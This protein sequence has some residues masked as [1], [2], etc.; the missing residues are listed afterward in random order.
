MAEVFDGNGWDPELAIN[1]WVYQKERARLGPYSTYHKTKLIVA[2]DGACRDNGKASAKA[3]VGVYFG[4]GN[5][6]NRA[7][8]LVDDPDITWTSQRAE[9]WAACRAFRLVTGMTMKVCRHCRPVFHRLR[10]DTIVLKSDSAY[11]VRGI[12]DFYMKWLVRLSKLG[13]P[14]AGRLRTY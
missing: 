12:T 6:H 9:L 14:L 13:Q 8:M 5:S 3:A 7:E 11:V 2:T 4:P 10:L 1:G